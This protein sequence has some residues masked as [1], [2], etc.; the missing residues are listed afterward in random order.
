MKVF[1]QLKKNLKQDFSALKTIKIALL[2]DTATQF[3]NQALRG[4]G[5]DRGYNLDIWEADFNQVEGQVFDPSSELYEFAPD[6]VV[7]FLS[8]S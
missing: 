2:G 8:Q 6:V 4:T 7:F 1:S 3:L 5:Y